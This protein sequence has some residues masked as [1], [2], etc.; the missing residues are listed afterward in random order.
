MSFGNFLRRLSTDFEKSPS[1]HE[2]AQTSENTGGINSIFSTPGKLLDSM[3]VKT[4]HL[5]SEM[6]Q[7]LDLGGKLDNLKQASI[8][9]LEHVVHG[10]LTQKEAMKPD[11]ERASFEAQN[12]HA[13]PFNEGEQTGTD[14]SLRRQSTHAGTRP[15]RP[16]PPNAVALSRAMSLDET[17]LSR[18][19]PEERKLSKKGGLSPTLE[20]AREAEEERYGGDRPAKDS[21]SAERKRS[22][23]ERSADDDDDRDSSASEYGTY[24]DQPVYKAETEDYDQ[25]STQKPDNDVRSAEE[26]DEKSSSRIKEV[27][28]T[29]VPALL[30]GRYQE[31]QHFDPELQEMLGTSQGRMEFVNFME[32]QARSSDN[33]LEVGNL[34]SLLEKIGYLLSECQDAEDF[35]P[36]KKLLTTSL[37]FY[38]QDSRAGT[39][40]AFLFVHIKTQPIWQ[41]LRFWNACFFQSVQEARAKLMEQSQ[42]YLNTMNVFDLHTTVKQEFLRKHSSLFNLPDG[43]LTMNSFS[44]SMPSEFMGIL[45]AYYR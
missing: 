43:S 1:T 23:S 14:K 21:L 26:L 36:A 2:S 13:N 11:Q 15:P 44:D 45:V 6:N 4:S 25:N 3:N 22:Y 8:T 39:E 24:G 37:L 28:K 16:P 38:V 31:V 18:N 33:V 41:S 10:T 12:V 7:K 20:P 35:G 27:M 40:R 17:N 5:V 32:K 30:H 19:K 29:C 34:P 42:S 9:K